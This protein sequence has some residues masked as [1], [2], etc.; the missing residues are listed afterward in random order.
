MNE[1][2]KER[3]SMAVG[4][5]IKNGKLQLSASSDSILPLPQDQADKIRRAALAK[6]GGLSRA[7]ALAL[8]PAED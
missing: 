3:S 6:F 4:R 2:K 1:R 5:G 8:K 7:V